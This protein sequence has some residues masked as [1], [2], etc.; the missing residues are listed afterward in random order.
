MTDLSNDVLTIPQAILD[1]YTVA[2]N[3]VS[4]RRF[5]DALAVYLP[6]EGEAYGQAMNCL[7]DVS[8]ERLGATFYNGACNRL[9]E[10]LIPL[11]DDHLL[12]LAEEHLRAFSVDESDVDGLL[13]A[14]L[15]GDLDLLRTGSQNALVL[16][17]DHHRWR[18]RVAFYWLNAINLLLTA[19]IAVLQGEGSSYVREKFLCALRALGN[20][21][22]EAAEYGLLLA[23]QLTAWFNNAPRQ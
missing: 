3:N 2:Y 6:R 14:K 15:L 12:V 13:T 4:Y 21:V 22:G 7:I 18:R 8:Y 1:A 23:S 16:A 17:G 11:A 9:A 5:G 19:T 10:V 20:G